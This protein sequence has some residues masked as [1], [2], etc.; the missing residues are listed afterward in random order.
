MNPV[1]CIDC[2]FF[3]GRAKRCVKTTKP[4]HQNAAWRYCTAYR[5]PGT[6]EPVE[7][8]APPAPTPAPPARERT[9]MELLPDWSP[10]RDVVSAVWVVAHLENIFTVTQKLRH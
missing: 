6:D 7:Q 4:V 10:A 2:R 5:A 8:P 1:R 9:G 3:T